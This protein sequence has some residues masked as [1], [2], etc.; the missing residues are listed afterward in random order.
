MKEDKTSRL[1]DKQ[2]RDSFY[3]KVQYSK[4]FKNNLIQEKLQ[5]PKKSI[6]PF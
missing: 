4:V 1:T 3:E 5:S 2:M 6:K